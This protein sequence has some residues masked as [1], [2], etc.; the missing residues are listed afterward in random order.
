MDEGILFL[1]LFILGVAIGVGIY[2]YREKEKKK[3]YKLIEMEIIENLKE[4]KPYVAPDESKEYTKE[5]DLVEVALSYDIEDIIVVNDEGLVIAST[6]KDA[7]NV[8]AIGLGIFEYIKK[9]HD[10]VKKI[11]IQRDEE[12]IHIYPLKLHGE[13]LYVIIESKI[14]LEVVEEREILRRIYDVLKKYF[15]NVETIEK[16]IPEEGQ[17]ILNV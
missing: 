5:F 11:I 2:Y 16:E 17:S 9:F 15:A 3:T 12:Y 7:D 10:N 4:L 14:M 8:G 13:N 1:I 6:L